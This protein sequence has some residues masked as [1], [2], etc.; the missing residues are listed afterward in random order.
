MSGARPG[1][2]TPGYKVGTLP[3]TALSTTRLHSLP[4]DCLGSECLQSLFLEAFPSAG[5]S[6]NPVGGSVDCG[7]SPGLGIRGLQ[8]GC[9]SAGN[10]LCDLD[11]SLSLSG[12]ETSSEK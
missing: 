7:E 9:G 8:P 11:N 10:S 2:G 5:L 1:Q 6:C 3:G 4:K 12:P